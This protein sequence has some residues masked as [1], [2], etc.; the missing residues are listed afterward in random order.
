MIR[1]RLTVALLIAADLA[2][3]STVS[4]VIV[5]IHAIGAAVLVVVPRLL[6][7]DETSTDETSTGDVNVT[8][9]I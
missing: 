9:E 8:P 7:P 5:A 1:N 4:L 6:P 3:W 2:L